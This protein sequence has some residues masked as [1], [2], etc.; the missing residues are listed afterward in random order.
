M[1]EKASNGM[2]SYKQSLLLLA[3]LLAA[4]FTTNIIFA[5]VFGS[6]TGEVGLGGGRTVLV[7]AHGVCKKVTNY[8]GLSFFVPTNVAT[9]WSDFRSNASNKNLADCTF[10]ELNASKSIPCERVWTPGYPVST[11][12]GVSASA[13]FAFTMPQGVY[14]WAAIDPSGLPWIRLQ[15]YC[16]SFTSY[17]TFDTN[18]VQT[19]SLN[20]QG[21]CPAGFG[22]LNNA[23]SVLSPSGFEVH[24]WYGGGYHAS[25]FMDWNGNV[26]WPPDPTPPP[27][28]PPEECTSNCGDSSGD[29]SGGD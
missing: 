15:G 6:G 13:C 25:F 5:A 2:K 16:A 29:S 26:S 21:Y 23:T 24:S 10:W 17:V 7:N 27:E 12:N 8:N 22:W 9:E 4:L 11:I 20:G 19:T 18:W 14:G 1:E 28:P 3:I